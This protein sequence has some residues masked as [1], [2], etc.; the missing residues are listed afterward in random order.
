MEGQI[1]GDMPGQGRQAPVLDDHAVYAAPAGQAQHPLRLR[2]LPVG[3]QRVER[4]IE[5]DAP[6]AAV[7]DGGGQLVLG[8]IPCA[9]PGVEAAAAQID[10]VRSVLNRRG[11]GLPVAGGR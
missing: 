11:H 1:R 3:E 6:E 7:L 8:E 5:L 4:Q 9:P 10:R 2:Q